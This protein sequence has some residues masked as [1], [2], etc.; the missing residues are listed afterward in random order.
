MTSYSYKGVYDIPVFEFEGHWVSILFG[1][2]VTSVS[3]GGWVLTRWHSIYLLGLQLFFI[4]IIQWYSLTTRKPEG[5]ILKVYRNL[6][7][8]LLGVVIIGTMAH[9]WY[10]TIYTQL[11][12]LIVLGFVFFSEITTWKVHSERKKFHS[13]SE[14]ELPVPK[15]ESMV[16]DQAELSKPS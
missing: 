11:Q 16:L 5:I 3:M 1:P 15:K 4:V 10:D 2:Y 6:T 8:I 14:Q 9:M 12:L 7:R 13:I